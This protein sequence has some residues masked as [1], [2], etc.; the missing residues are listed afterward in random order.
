MSKTTD[1]MEFES[2]LP[3]TQITSDQNGLKC[4]D[5]YEHDQRKE[6]ITNR[7]LLVR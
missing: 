3:A 4:G 6:K 1:S 2:M 5:Q 7:R